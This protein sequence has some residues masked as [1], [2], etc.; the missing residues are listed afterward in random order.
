M[1]SVVVGDLES[2]IP[3]LL[4]ILSLSCEHEKLSVRLA[5]LAISPLDQHEF[6]SSDVDWNQ[7]R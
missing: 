1:M 6:R 5:L 2:N 7:I 3:L 4:Y